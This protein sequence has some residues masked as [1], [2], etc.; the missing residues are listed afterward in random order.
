MPKEIFVFES[1]ECGYHTTSIGKLAK[2]KYG[3][4]DF[5]GIGYHGQS[6]AIPTLDMFGEK[7]SIREIE[8]YINEFL[9]FVKLNKRKIFLLNK[10]GTDRYGMTEKESNSLFNFELP[11][12]IKWL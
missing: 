6:Y 11:K 7:L 10:I 4:E 9:D 3:A 2:K 8:L 1:D 5:V 12:N